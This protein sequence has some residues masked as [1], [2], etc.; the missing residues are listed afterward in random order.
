MSANNDNMD[1]ITRAKVAYG[2]RAVRA[3]NKRRRAVRPLAAFLVLPAKKG[4]S[5]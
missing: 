4:K 2:S 5:K 1:S 3:T